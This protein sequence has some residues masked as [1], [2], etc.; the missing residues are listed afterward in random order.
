[1][2]LLISQ[3]SQRAFSYLEFENERNWKE[4]QMA[5]IDLERIG[6]YQ[7]TAL[8]VLQE[9]NGQLASREVIRQVEKKL[10]L[11]DYERAQLEHSGYIR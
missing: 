8:E 11:S 9:N 4:T 1:M 7:K 2:E 6:V 10:K 3:R 5:K